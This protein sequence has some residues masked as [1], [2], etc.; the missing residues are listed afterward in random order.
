[1][2]PRVTGPRVTLATTCVLVLICAVTWLSFT[3]GRLL[4]WSPLFPGSA[5]GGSRDGSAGWRL[6]ALAISP[7]R[8]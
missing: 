2:R 7:T 5:A 1:M 6:P 3:T 8:R 4:G